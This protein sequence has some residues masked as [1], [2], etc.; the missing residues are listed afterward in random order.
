[1][2]SFTLYT[3]SLFLFL[4]LL[5]L[6]GWFFNPFVS[7]AAN[8]TPT[9]PIPDALSRLENPQV[10]SLTFWDPSIGSVGN[11]DLTA[12]SVLSYDLTTNTVLYAKNPT[13]ELPMASLTKIMTAIIALEN[14]KTPDSYLVSNRDLVGEDSMGLSAGESL[15]LSDL[16]YGLV[17]HS[18]NDAA[19]T[20]ADNY[21]QGTAAF[22][23]AMNEKAQALGLTH[24]HF[25][26]PTGLEGDGDQHTTA[27][28]LL[29][30][31]RYA[32]LQFPLFDQVVSTFDYTI[33]A[34]ATHKAYDLENETNLLSS[35][36]GVKG[37]KDG[38]TP[39]AG[40]CLVTYLDYGG[41]QILA[42]ILGSDNRRGEMIDVLDYSLKKL[43]ITP[44]QHE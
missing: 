10:T 28:D 1:M 5:S 40:L 13:K 17:L 34:T 38:Y 39:Q 9:I 44:P 30:M 21:P 3:L 23:V 35:Y 37:V 11:L 31:T 29:I 32:L 12:T 2:R 8:S 24:T 27:A 26:N 20:I 42:V 6:V 43:G 18:G 16:L 36:P 14:P 7:H 15:P 33:P 25:T 41:H 4:C 19:E 22:V